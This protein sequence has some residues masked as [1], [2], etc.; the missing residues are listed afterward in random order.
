M[1]PTW[2]PEGDTATP[3]DLPIRALAKICQQWFDAVGDQPSP[4]PE[5]CAP[6]PGDDSQRLLIKIDILKNA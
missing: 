6:K 5:G 4:F 1:P 3:N 2:L